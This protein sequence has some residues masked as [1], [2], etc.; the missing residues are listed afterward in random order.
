[1]KSFIV[2]LAEIMDTELSTLAGSYKYQVFGSHT[3]AIEG[4]TGLSHFA[5]SNNSFHVAGGILAVLGENLTITNLTK[6]FAVV[7]GTIKSVEVR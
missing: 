7:K 2:P 1:M 3:C 6:N 5:S 4:H